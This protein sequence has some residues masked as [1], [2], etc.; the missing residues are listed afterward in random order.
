[1]IDSDGRFYYISVKEGSF[2]QAIRISQSGSYTVAI[3][4]NSSQTVCVVGFVN[5]LLALVMSLTLT[6]PA[7]AAENAEP[8]ENVSMEDICIVAREDY[9]IVVSV[10]KSE[11][12]AYQKRLETEP[13]FKEEEI[14]QAWGYTSSSATRALP[15][16]IIDYQSYMYKGDIERMVDAYAGSGAFQKW[17][18]RAG[19]A[20]TAADI[21]EL[22]KLTK[23]QSAAVLAASIL[24]STTSSAINQSEIWW[25]ESYALIINGEILAV[26][27]TVVQNITE[28]PK[29]WL[30]Y[31]RI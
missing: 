3:R 23:A 21:L 2:N 5:Y 12:E 28:Y 20:V 15:P 9:V 29:A 17:L 7:F 22:I 30:I 10:P 18:E 4:N 16:G 25:R 19:W 11:S 13:G 24:L 31:E 8:S 1:M 6:A 27:Y 14:R 26:R